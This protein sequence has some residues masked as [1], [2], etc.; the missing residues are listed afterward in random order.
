MEFTMPQACRD[1]NVSSG[2][3]DLAVWDIRTEVCSLSFQHHLQNLARSPF[4]FPRLRHVNI[5]DAAI[6]NAKQTRIVELC[7][8]RSL[9]GFGPKRDVRIVC[10]RH[11]WKCLDDYSMSS[12][13]ALKAAK[14]ALDAGDFNEAASQ[15]RVV[16]ESDS[17]NYFA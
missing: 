3:D 1:S 2:C 10:V 16:L 11:I 4:L 5:Y 13:A 17:K 15:A 7:I 14:A 8:Y 9:K 12:K 6:E